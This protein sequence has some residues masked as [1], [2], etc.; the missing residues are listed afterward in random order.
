MSRDHLGQF[1]VGSNLGFARGVLLLED[2][3]G[4]FVWTATG[5]GGD[6][7]HAWATAA[8]FMGINGLRL[9][10]RT[11][12]AAAADWLT[13]ART[14]GFPETGLLV[15]RVRIAGV[16]MAAIDQMGITLVA[17]NGTRLWQSALVVQPNVP[18]CSYLNAAGGLTAIPALAYRP[19]DLSY[20]TL[21]LVIDLLANEYLEASW[22]GVRADLAGAGLSD[23]GADATRRAYLGASV[24]SLAAA[25]AE[26]YLDNLYVG[27]FLD[28]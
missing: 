21:E 9:K 14:F 16:S 22:C 3:E 15:A 1:T 12:G 6:D 27:E 28:L 26:I 20:Q 19:G 5:T 24:V 17:A 23:S 10:T 8:A 2:C 7:V 11:T 25:P 18:S 13:A 4:T